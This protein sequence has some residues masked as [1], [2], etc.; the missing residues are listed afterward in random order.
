MMASTKSGKLIHGIYRYMPMINRR[1]SCADIKGGDDFHAVIPKPVIFH[2]GGSQLARAD[3]HSGGGH[4]HLQ[5]L[6][7]I[8]E[9]GRNGVAHFGKTRRAYAGQVFAHLY[10]PQ[11]QASG[12]LRG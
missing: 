6:F 7:H 5:R 4:I 10:F 3:N 11:A 1:G 8:P 2:Q 12:N 9:K